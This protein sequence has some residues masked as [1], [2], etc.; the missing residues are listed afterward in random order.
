MA[1]IT[2]GY[3]MRNS[4]M[5]FASTDYAA[6]V[7]KARLVPDAPIQTYRTLTPDGVIQDIDSTVWTLE[8]EGVSDWET[9]G[10]SSYLNTNAGTTVTCILAPRKNSGNLQ[11]TFSVII[12]PGPFGGEQGS[13]V[14]FDLTF[15]VVG[16]PVFAAQA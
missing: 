11:A 9:G 3:V 16:A 15:P 10:L 2:G 13:F 7:R 1:V 6:Q 4:I 5:K 8:V 14:D 12:V